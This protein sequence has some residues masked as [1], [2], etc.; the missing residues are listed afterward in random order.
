MRLAG[1]VAR[2]PSVFSAGGMTADLRAGE[3]LALSCPERRFLGAHARDQS[4]VLARSRRSTDRERGEAGK[5]QDDRRGY[6]EAAQHGRHL[7]GPLT[8]L[9]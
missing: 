4:F 5:P 2:S 1:E 8:A 9:R 7:D 6:G 3:A